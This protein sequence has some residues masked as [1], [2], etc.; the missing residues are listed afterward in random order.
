MQQD[1][2]RFAAD[3]G[4]HLP[5]HR[6]LGHEA[7]RPA[8]RARRRWTAHHREDPWLVRGR[9]HLR[10]AGSRGIKPRAGHAARL[11]PPGDATNRRRRQVERARHFR[12]PR[13]AIQVQQRQHA[14]DPPRLLHPAV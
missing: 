6:L 14:E 2:D 8:G 4:H 12:R 13:A 1:A 9:K 5:R 3:A 10:R 7:Q 11:V